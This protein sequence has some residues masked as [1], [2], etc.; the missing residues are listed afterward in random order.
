LE[1]VASSVTGNWRAPTIAHL[2]I[3]DALNAIDRRFEP[4]AV[5][6]WAPPDS[7]PEAA[8]SAAAHTV[9]IRLVPAAA[10]T[11]DAAYAQWLLAIPPGSSRDAGIALGERVADRLVGLRADEGFLVPQFY[12]PVPG[13]GIWQPTPPAFA[14]AAT[15]EWRQCARLR[16][17]RRRS[18][19]R[20]LHRPSAKAGTPAITTRCG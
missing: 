6:E 1:T 15:P 17:S 13:I 14:P 18:S 4:Y 19:D 16:W 10:A 12:N 3:H 7:S 2:A 9:L 11:I 5:D 8:V 20:M